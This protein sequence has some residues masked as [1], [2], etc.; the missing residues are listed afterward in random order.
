MS[1]TLT[2]ATSPLPHNCNLVSN[3]GSTMDI[4]YLRRIGVLLYIS[5]GSRP[6]ITFAVN[7]LARFLMGTYVSHWHALEHLLSYLRRSANTGTWILPECKGDAFECYTNANW[8]GEGSCSTHGFLML[9]RGSP[10]SWQSKRQPTVAGSTCQAEYI[11]LSFAAKECLWLSNLFI[12]TIGKHIPKIFSDNKAAINI[13]SNTT[14][15]KQ[16]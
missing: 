3:T 11:A 12:S 6:D 14:S 2:T 4:E 10:I 15:R 8:G 7:Y 1:T 5:Q 9:Y 13:S 16:T